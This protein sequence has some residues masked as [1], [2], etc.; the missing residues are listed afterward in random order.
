MET[1]VIAGA[2][3]VLK[4]PRKMGW[5]RTAVV[6]KSDPDGLKPFR[7]SRNGDEDGS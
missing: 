2:N 1:V 4:P 3:R 7:K 6:G 5:A